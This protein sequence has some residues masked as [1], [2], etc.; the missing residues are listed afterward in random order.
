MIEVENLAK[1]YGPRS[2]IHGLTFQVNKGEVV[3]F[4]GPNGAGKTTTMNIL[5]CILPASSGTAR[6]CGFDI[7]E[8]SYEIRKRIGYLPETP[9][10]YQDMVVSNYLTFVAGLRG[11]PKKQIAAAVD[12]VL[13]QCHI[14]DVHE[15]I[16]GRLS[17]GY[18]QRIGLA[19]AMIHD[20]E[21]LILDEPTIGLDPIQIIEIRKLIQE[22]G[23][24]HT[25]LLSSHILP[26][27][28]QICQRVIIINEGSIAA[29][30]TL[31]GLN[32]S[33]RHSNRLELRVRNA[34]NGIVERLQAL[35]SVSAVHPDGPNRFFIESNAN[36]P[37]QDDVARLVLEHG[38][39]IEELKPLA[40]SLEDIFLK[41]TTEEKLVTPS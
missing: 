40:M 20:P 2:A 8:Q 14:Q 17:K 26:E 23:K 4:L 3:G 39:G 12:R 33:L 22:L 34:G 13:E 7:F 27:V 32:A 31:Q 29:M 36:T 9:P 35:D 6:V 24:A 19:Q 1:S 21:I 10:L 25:I 28:T 11:V 15:R 30:D 37:V 18:Q 41:L 38:W 16:I 5:C